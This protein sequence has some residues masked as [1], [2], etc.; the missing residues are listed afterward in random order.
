[1]PRQTYRVTLR[2]ISLESSSCNKEKMEFSSVVLGLEAIQSHAMPRQNALTAKATL[3]GH[4]SL[5]H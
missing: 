3:S 2:R 5:L 1:M 4:G